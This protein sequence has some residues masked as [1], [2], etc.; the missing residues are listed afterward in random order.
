MSPVRP[1]RCLAISRFTGK[2]SVSSVGAP[3]SSS[4]ANLV[5]ITDPP[6][7]RPAQSRPTRANPLNPLACGFCSFS[8]SRFNCAQ[9]DHRHVQFLRQ[10]LDAAG[11]IG[12][13]LLAVVLRTPRNG[14]A[15]A[16]NNQPQRVSRHAAGAS[17][18]PRPA[19]QNRK[20]RRIVAQQFR[21][22]QPAP[23]RSSILENLI[24]S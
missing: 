16:A 24:R 14:N 21:L 20:P 23:P 1:L 2:P 17:A 7:R 5:C 18:A 8:S 15:K 11:N 9:H 4:P 13:F 10:C 3:S 22:R 6:H 12:D 19:V